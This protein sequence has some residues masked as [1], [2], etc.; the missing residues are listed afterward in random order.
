MT[1]QINKFYAVQYNAA[2]EGCPDNL[3]GFFNHA[4]FE[5]SPYEYYPELLEI[6]NEYRLALSDPNINFDILSFDFYQIGVTYVSRRFLKVCDLLSARYRAVPLEISLGD[7]IRKE[8]YFI[9]LPGESLP[10][11]DKAL[12]VYEAAKDF[13]TGNVIASPL[14]PGEVTIEKI[15]SFAVLPGIESDIFRCQETL[16]LFCSDR[17]KSAAKGLKGIS[18]VAIDENYR[19]D[20]WSD[21][22]EL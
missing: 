10:A 18:F 8:D 9:F 22:E 19:Y 14:Y 5:W 2:D 12:S 13:E 4:S 3:T 15:D 17:F 16:Q 20:P 7:K 6:K 1:L 21:F 11:L